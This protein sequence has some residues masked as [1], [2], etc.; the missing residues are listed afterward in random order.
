MVKVKED[1]TGMVF[2]RLT[3]VGQG[4]DYVDKKGR[5]YSQWN[6]VC[7]CGTPSTVRGGDIK[8]GKIRS[9]GCFQ[10]EFFAEKT[11]ERLKIYNDYE[12]QEDYV[13][14][15]TT[16]GEPFYVDLEDFWKVKDI[17]WHIKKNG[18]V[19]GKHGKKSVL[20]HR[21]ITGC[22]KK[23]KVDHIGGSQTKNDN[24]KR[25][26][27][28]CSQGQNS[29]NRKL[30]KRNKYNCGGIS[31]I[32]KL[33]KYQASIDCDN[34]RIYL[35]IY[36]NLEDAIAVRKAAEDKYFGEFS[37]DNSQTLANSN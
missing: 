14:M 28:I 26:L 9:C 8:K 20:L 15:Y 21:F 30:D 32:P 18:Y 2:G 36:T 33:N 27:R 25:N 31:Y 6:C 22:P 16:K 10:K 3:V 35:G 23:M 24:R 29:K 13:I 12:I 1:L 19:E 4:Q 37:Y 7:S 5:H 17:C 11:K 34:Q